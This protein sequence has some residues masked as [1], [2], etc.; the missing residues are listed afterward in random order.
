MPVTQQQEAKKGVDVKMG[1]SQA[2]TVTA[3]VHAASSVIKKRMVVPQD[4]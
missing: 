1:S 4:L 2:A 3:M